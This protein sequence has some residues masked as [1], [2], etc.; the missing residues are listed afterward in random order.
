MA[1]LSS[2]S[3]GFVKAT[4]TASIRRIFYPVVSSATEPAVLVSNGHTGKAALADLEAFSFAFARSYQ[5][6]TVSA[7]AEAQPLRGA[8]DYVEIKSLTRNVAGAGSGG[9]GIDIYDEGN[10]VAA[11]ITRLDFKGADIEARKSSTGAVVFSPVPAYVSN[12]NTQD[13]TSDARV[14]S[15]GFTN[16]YIAAPTTEGAPFYSGGFGG[17]DATHP[18]TRSNTITF[19]V[20]DFFAL[21]SL[22]TSITINVSNATGIIDTLNIEMIDGD[23]VAASGNGINASISEFQSDADRFKAKLGVVLNHGQ[24]LSGSSGAL[25]LSISHNNGG[26]FYN[27]A[28]PIWFYDSEPSVASL[29]GATVAINTPAIKTLSGI[30]YFGLGSTFDVAVADI[31]NLNADTYPNTQVVVTMTQFG[32]G[33]S[34]LSGG[35]L[36][37]WTSAWDNMNASLDVTLF[38]TNQA[39]FRFEGDATLTARV[40][41]WSSGQSATDVIRSLVDTFG[42]TS[43]DVSESFND[44][45][46]RVLS[47]GTAWNSNQALPADALMVKGGRLQVQQGDWTAFNPNPAGQPDYSAGGAITQTYYR[48]FS[49][50]DVKSGGVFSLGV[51]TE[52]D[53]GSNVVIEISLNGV[54]WYTLSQGYL[55]GAL[56]NGAGC[57]TNADQYQMPSVQFTLATFST[58]DASGVVP[59]KSLMVRVSMPSTSTLALESLNLAWN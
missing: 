39:N 52:A 19:E 11:N 59:A 2:R 53:L 6:L 48:L 12:F 10:L 4:L 40:V 31:D 26:V 32:A 46:R 14:V 28:S 23:I 34:N 36:V 21:S 37:G 55:G 30:S 56:T 43:S 1:S 50:P 16:R 58:A 51:G 45:A 44:E 57:R 41:D 8:G 18:T 33:A 20:P 27:F 38:T 15:P 54:D 24:L 35:D 9:K 3:R 29:S 22:G 17:D 42:V 25:S 47:D 13:G 5:G 49:S 7:V